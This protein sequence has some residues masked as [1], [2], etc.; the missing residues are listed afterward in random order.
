M[1]G[2]IAHFARRGLK[3]PLTEKCWSRILSSGNSGLAAAHRNGPG[4]AATQNLDS[5][6]TTVYVIYIVWWV[7]KVNS[8]TKYWVIKDKIGNL[9]YQLCIVH[10]YRIW[11]PTHV[12]ETSTSEAIF[13]QIYLPPIKVSA[14]CALSNGP[15]FLQRIIDKNGKKGKKWGNLQSLIVSS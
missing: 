6:A 8:C 9:F 13:W 5:T 12:D 7:Q 14:R 4:L 2:G 1:R 11:V 3:T 10:T 15:I